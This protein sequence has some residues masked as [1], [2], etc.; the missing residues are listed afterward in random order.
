MKPPRDLARNLGGLLTSQIRQRRV[1]RSGEAA[2][3]IALALAVA[4]H[5]QLTHRRF[6]R[7]NNQ[8]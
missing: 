4:N 1:R 8:D 5:Y 7:R 6:P 3:A 2:I